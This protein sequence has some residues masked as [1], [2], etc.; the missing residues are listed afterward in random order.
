M[1]NY[2]APRIEIIIL[3]AYLF[4]LAFLTFLFIKFYFYYTK[5]IKNSKKDSLAEILNEILNQEKEK[6]EEIFKINKKIDELFKN[7]SFHI[8]KVGLLRF[9]PFKDT[10]GDQ[11]FILALLDSHDTGV[12]MS[13]LHTRAGTRWYA[14]RVINGVGVDYELSEEEKKTLK[15]AQHLPAD[16]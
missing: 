14:K 1:V 13:S 9:N 11:S 5:I 10:G 15:E 12:V 6:E 4:W 2:M 3:S 7:A 8:Q 16:K